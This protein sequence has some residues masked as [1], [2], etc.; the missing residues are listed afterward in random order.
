MGHKSTKLG[1][2]IFKLICLE[3]HL[4]ANQEIA[5]ATEKIVERSQA[6]FKGKLAYNWL[7][8]MFRFS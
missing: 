5:T 2:V 8:K 3:G 7:S 1:L 4:N 6:P